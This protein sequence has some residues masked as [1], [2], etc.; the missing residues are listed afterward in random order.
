MILQVFYCNVSDCVQAY[1]AMCYLSLIVYEGVDN[2]CLT[3]PLVIIIIIIVMVWLD[4]QGRM[5]TVRS[6][7]VCV[8][9][10]VTHSNNMN[11]FSC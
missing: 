5:F 11:G 7:V 4:W 10:T 3:N 8:E 2:W 6:V 9:T 1:V